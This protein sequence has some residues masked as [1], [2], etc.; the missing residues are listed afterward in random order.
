MATRFLKSLTAAVMLM[1]LSTA[2]SANV[3]SVSPAG[4]LAEIGDTVTVDLS[5]SFLQSTVG[6]SF[7]LTYDPTL[8]NLVSFDFDADFINNVADPAFA[9]TPDFCFTDGAAMGGCDVGDG[10][11]N[12]IGF[13]SF[14]GIIGDYLIGTVTFEALASGI[15]PLLLSTNDTP[16]EGFIGLNGAELNV[17]YG[18]GKIRVVPLPAA[19][20][21][22]LGG[23]GALL[24]I[25][26]RRS[27]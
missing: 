2:A 5:M 22:L 6:G 10:E 8:L 3:I 21:L 12:A 24:G 11:L 1:G 23:L 25:G 27:V 26:R 13:G 20:W 4:Q 18:P 16:F 14:D 7:D 9:V 15:S 19:A 17:L